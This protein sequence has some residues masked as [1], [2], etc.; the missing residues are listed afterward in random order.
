MFFETLTAGL[1]MACGSAGAVAYTAALRVRDVRAEPP[2]REGPV[3]ALGG[4]QAP[5]L[6]RHIGHKARLLLAV[7]AV[8]VLGEL[9][10][11]HILELLLDLGPL[12][13]RHGLKLLFGD[14]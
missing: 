8:G 12:F 7:G 4:L 9:L 11:D 13:G 10:F 2:R 5:R 6:D 3:I 14:A 1:V